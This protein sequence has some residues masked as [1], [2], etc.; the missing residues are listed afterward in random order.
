MFSSV[1]GR[2]PDWET[3]TKILFISEHYRNEEAEVQDVIDEGDELYSYEY[4]L[5]GKTLRITSWT[6]KRSGPT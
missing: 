3:K 5:V 1:F 4:L 2:N 6:T